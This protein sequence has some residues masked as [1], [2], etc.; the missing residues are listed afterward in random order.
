MGIHL[1]SLK[2]LL[3]VTFAAAMVL[4]ATSGAVLIT[5]TGG[6]WDLGSG[7]GPAC[8]DAACD[9]EGDTGT[10]QSKVTGAH[11]LLNM[12]WAIDG[13]LTHQLFDLN[14]VG[15]SWT[16]DFGTG[17][18]MDEDNKLD[19]DEIDDLD[20]VGILD[21]VVLSGI[22]NTGAVTT[23][24]GSLNDG[25]NDLV[26]DFAPVLVTL[27]DG[28]AFTIDLSDPIW[29]CN[30]GSQDCSYPQSQTRTISATFTLTNLAEGDPDGDPGG[31]PAAIPEPGILALLAAGLLGMGLARRRHYG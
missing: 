20:I 22:A 5:I 28:T 29:N 26:I 2:L 10:G 21:L 12:D 1:P 7:W 8:A 9:G 11:T 31:G 14:A 18:F 3:P 16:V 19:S 17:K 4:P 15:D 24:T 23:L 13:S 25:A 6:S 27:V 30:P